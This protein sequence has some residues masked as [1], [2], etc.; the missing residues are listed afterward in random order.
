MAPY[1]AIDFPH[2]LVGKITQVVVFAS[3][4]FASTVHASETALPPTLEGLGIKAQTAARSADAENHLG[5]RYLT[6]DGIVRDPELA[7]K[8]LARAAAKGDAHAQY[9]MGVI[10]QRGLGTAIDLK[11]SEAFYRASAQ[12]NYAEAEFS[13]AALLANDPKTKDEASTW[14]QKA[15]GNGHG[16]A[17]YV[18]GLMQFNGINMPKDRS[19]GLALLTQAANKGVVGAQNQLGVIYSSEV[20]MV[21]DYRKSLKWLVRAAQRDYAPAENN[22][23]VMYRSGLGLP[24]NDTKAMLWFFKSARH[25]NPDAAE[26]IGTF[27]ADI[28]NKD[29]RLVDAYSWFLIAKAFGSAKAD[30]NIRN[31]KAKMSVSDTQRSIALARNILENNKLRQPGI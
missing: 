23:G 25:L 12:Q 3:L 5:A 7:R 10:F 11:A 2:S 1:K 13:L 17:A 28:K 9:N 20:E 4:A 29:Q 31:I 14:L 6:G 19:A 15:V 21:P 30:A 24:H 16:E 27:Y 18:L 26:N 8:L 22:L